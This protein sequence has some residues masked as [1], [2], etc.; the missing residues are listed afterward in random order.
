M[1]RCKVNDIPIP[2]NLQALLTAPIDLLDDDTRRTLHL[3]SVIGQSFHHGVLKLISDSSTALDRQLS[4]LQQV[5]LIREAG[6]VPELEYIF[7]DDLTREAAYNS[8]LLREH[9][10]FL[11]TC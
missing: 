7:Q 6:R 3:S 4:A 9:L 1:C 11:Q 2:E 10:G 5:G 8:V